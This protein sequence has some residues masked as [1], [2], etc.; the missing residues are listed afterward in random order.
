MQDE[1]WERRSETWT[2][3][4]ADAW[5][6]MLSLGTDLPGAEQVA[7][8]RRAWADIAEVERDRA[9]GER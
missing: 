8:N 7:E 5:G 4:E 6:L 3:E 1:R 9:G 2:E